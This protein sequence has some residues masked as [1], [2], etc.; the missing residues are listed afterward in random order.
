MPHAKGPFLSFANDW[1]PKNF[2]AGLATQI[3]DILNR[4]I[5]GGAQV[6]VVLRIGDVREVEAQDAFSSTMFVISQY[7]RATFSAIN[8]VDFE[9]LSH[10][11]VFD[12]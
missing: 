4:G 1:N 8:F 2:T 12:Y 7:I 5:I 11:Q 6:S 3:W 9:P 10:L